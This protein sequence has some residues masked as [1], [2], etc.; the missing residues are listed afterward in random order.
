MN[1]PHR[2]EAS[3][4]KMLID[5]ERER[6]QP[7]EGIVQRAAPTLDE[8]C[9]DLGCGPG[10]LTIPFARRCK[11]TI[12]VDVQPEM[13]VTLMERVAQAGVGRVYPVQADLA[14][15]PVLGASLDRVIAANVVHEVDDREALALEIE[16]VL[17][18]GGK[19]T[20]IE[21]PKRPTSRGPPFEERLTEEE[22]IAL[23]P[24]MSVEKRW[25]FDEFYQIEMV[26]R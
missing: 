20:L 2:F 22:A 8:V 7:S 12:A 4:K 6:I 3:A 25:S 11:A 16:R 19:V 9:A 26:R 17:R 18:A 15:L 13:L 21:F 23:F 24:S 5:E 1:V 10:Y 14:R